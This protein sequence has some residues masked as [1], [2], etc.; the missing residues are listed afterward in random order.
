MGLEYT[1]RPHLICTQ[2]GIPEKVVIVFQGAKGAT[3]NPEVCLG[4]ASQQQI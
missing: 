1:N 4:V 2:E 3:P